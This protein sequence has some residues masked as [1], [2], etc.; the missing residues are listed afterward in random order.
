MIVRHDNV[1]V[2]KPWGSHHAP[3]ETEPF[4]LPFIPVFSVPTH[5]R[6]C[7]KN[8][9]SGIDCN[10]HYAHR[11]ARLYDSACAPSVGNL[12]P[13]PNKE[14]SWDY[15]HRMSFDWGGCNGTD[16]TW[17][18][19]PNLDYNVHAPD[20]ISSV[21]HTCTWRWDQDTVRWVDTGLIDAVVVDNGDLNEA[22]GAAAGAAC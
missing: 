9:D 2:I 22:A 13:C 19:A 8:L 5:V 17:A 21:Q 7:Q 20:G 16:F 10:S 4:S 15:Y 1:I 6:W 18:P 11:D 12:T 3:Y 14:G